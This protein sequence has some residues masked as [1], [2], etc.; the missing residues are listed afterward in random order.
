MPSRVGY[1][2]TLATEVAA[3]DA[4]IASVAGVSVTAIE[5]VCVPADDFTDPA[6]TVIARHLDSIA[7]PQFCG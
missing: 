7:P 3:L 4:R 6:V 2:P 5:A 1:Q